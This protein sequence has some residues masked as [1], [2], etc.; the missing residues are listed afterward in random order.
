MPSLQDLLDQTMLFSAARGKN[1]PV[2]EVPLDGPFRSPRPNP[3]TAEKV[4]HPLSEDTVRKNPIW[5]FSWDPA[6]P[7][8]FTKVQIFSRGMGMDYGMAATAFD[9]IE[10]RQLSVLRE[11]GATVDLLLDPDHMLGAWWLRQGHVGP[12]SSGLWQLDART[13][14]S[15]LVVFGYKLDCEKALPLSMEE[16]EVLGDTLIPAADLGPRQLDVVAGPNSQYWV[17]VGPVRYIV[18]IELVLCKEHNDFVPGG[19]V[20]FARAHPHAFFW[21][22]EPTQRFEANIILQRPKHAMSH[23]DAMGTEHKALLVT[24][25]NCE[26][27]PTAIFGLPIPTTDRLYDYYDTEPVERLAARKKGE[28]D[29]PLQKSFEFTLADSRFPKKGR[30]I[31]DAIKRKS[32][33]VAAGS[34][35]GKEPRQGQFDNVHLAPRMKLVM[36]S[37]TG[38]RTVYEDVVML[39]TCLHDCTHMHVRWA[40]FL[41]DKILKGWKDG[42]PFVES[43]APLVPDNQ[44][45]FGSLPNAHTLRYRAVSEKD[46]AGKCVV[47]FHHGLAYAVDQWPGEAVAANILLM[48]NSIKLLAAQ[49]Q[50]PWY[51]DVAN[52]EWA[53]FYWRVRFI[54]K[55]N[56]I[57]ARSEFDIEEC[58]R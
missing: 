29:H 37:V 16:V 47:I 50:E 17:C 57:E 34:D 3:V 30:V 27:D 20:G 36:T 5:Q 9:K 1:L 2:A 45:I 42:R 58:M 46:E 35:C 38:R 4:G 25:T 54:G 33:L 24:D 48:R 56:Y 19:F 51:S 43:G 13:D 31:P 39:N 26:H 8:T 21:S 11:T 7:G 6:N 22:N 23:G 10:F 55:N 41:K 40:A 28:Y 44:V 53:L 32:P 12:A 49:F 52:D 15:L 14:C 18:A